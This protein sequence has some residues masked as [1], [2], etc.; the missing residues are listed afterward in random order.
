[1][2]VILFDLMDTL[3][4]DPVYSVIPNI[5][6]EQNSLDHFWEYKNQ[7]ATDLFERGAINENEFFNQMYLTDTP[8]DIRKKLIQPINYKNLLLQK[9]TFVKGMEELWDEL[10]D[11]KDI[12]VGIASNYS[13]WYHNILQR[14]PKLKAAAYYFFSCEL[15]ARKPEEQFYEVIKKNLP[16]THAGDIFFTDNV[17]ENLSVPNQLG[18]TTHHMEGA[19]ATDDAIRNF[20]GD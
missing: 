7:E 15:S 9:I 16:H 10:I 13:E 12:E 1:M 4:E 5:F 18:W 8:P 17:K 3:I 20:L 6:L 11:R 2:K 19:S 14:I